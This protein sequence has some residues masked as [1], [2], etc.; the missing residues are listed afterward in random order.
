[1]YLPRR[2]NYFIC[3]YIKDNTFNLYKIKSVTTENIR[4]NRETSIVV[5]NLP[6]LNIHK[7]TERERE[8]KQKIIRNSKYTEI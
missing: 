6:L 1:M 8:R 7:L 5:Q 2:H 3:I 4:R